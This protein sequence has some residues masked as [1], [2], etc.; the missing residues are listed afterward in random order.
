M[1]KVTD[2]CFFKYRP[3]DKRLLESLIH[4]SIYFSHRAQLNDPF[5]CNVDIVRAL[6]HA[7]EGGSCKSTVLLQQ[8]RRDEVVH[9]KFSKNVAALGVGS[10]SLTNSETL[11]WSHYANDHKGAVMRYSFPMDFLDDEEN[12][13]GV[14]MVS[15]KP[16][17]IS[18]WLV[19]NAYL[20]EENHQEFITGL[21]KK[22]LMSKAPAWSYEQEARIV[23]PESGLFEVPRSTLTHVI[24]GLQTSKQ[25]ENLVRAV[26]EKYYD[27]VGFG[28]AARTSDDFG[29][30]IIEIQ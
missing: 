3:I 9:R 29:I 2:Y 1:S 26:M 30:E 24:F 13:L 21:L 14:S 4:S 25:D 12:I 27:G 6:D 10:F 11:L 16:N 19:E 15:Y 20:Y 22:V 23:R 8:F 18:D 5:D 17:A 7:V 28:R